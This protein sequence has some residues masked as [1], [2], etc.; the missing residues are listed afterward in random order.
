MTLVSGRAVKLDKR[1]FNFW[2]PGKDWLFIAS[3]AK[4]GQQ[5][6]VDEVNAGVQQGAVASR[7]IKRNR[8]LDHVAEVVEFMAPPLHVRCHAI[9]RPLTNVVRIEVAARFLNFNDFLNEDRKSTRLNSSHT[10][11]SYAVF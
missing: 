2:M 6:A 8:A 1:Q 5:V 10:V 7:A 3:L 11:I 9:L 4:I